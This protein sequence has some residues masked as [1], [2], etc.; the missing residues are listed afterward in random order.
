[1]PQISHE[2]IRKLIRQTAR[3]SVASEQDVNPF[4]AVL[5][6]NYGVAYLSSLLELSGIEE[7]E[8]VSGVNMQRF[9]HEIYSN[10]DRATKRMI[11][12]CPYYRPKNIWLS[13]I[14]MEY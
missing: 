7:I 2:G 14:A 12:Y 11:T 8:K 1:M 10:Q 4:I 5:H 3:W 6:A 9:I 13:R